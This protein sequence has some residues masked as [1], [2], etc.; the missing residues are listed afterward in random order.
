MFISIELGDTHGGVVRFYELGQ[1]S[2]PFCQK[3]DC[4]LSLIQSFLRDPLLLAFFFF[5]C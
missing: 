4:L 2:Y 1:G 3:I 5:V